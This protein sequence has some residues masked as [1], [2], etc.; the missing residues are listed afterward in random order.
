[1]VHKN[2]ISDM[3]GLFQVLWGMLPPNDHC[4]PMFVPGRL[5]PIVPFSLFRPHVA[6]AGAAWRCRFHAS[7]SSENCARAS[8]TSFKSWRRWVEAAWNGSNLLAS[9]MRSGKPSCCS[10]VSR[11][12]RVCS[13]MEVF[14]FAWQVAFRRSKFLHSYLG[15]CWE[16]YS[17]WNGSYLEHCSHSTCSS[18]ITFLDALLVWR[19]ILHLCAYVEVSGYVF[20]SDL[21]AISH[22]RSLQEDLARLEFASKRHLLATCPLA[23]SWALV[24]HGFRFWPEHL[25]AVADLN[26]SGVPPSPTRGKLNH[27]PLKKW[28]VWSRPFHNTWVPLLYWLCFTLCIGLAESCLPLCCGV[29]SILDRAEEVARREGQGTKRC[30][31]GSFACRRS[32]SLQTKG[33]ISSLATTTAPFVAAIYETFIEART[34]PID[35]AFDQIRWNPS[36]SYFFYRCAVCQQFGECWCYSIIK[37]W[38]VQ[39]VSTSSPRILS[40]RLRNWRGRRRLRSWP[41]RG[42]SDRATLW[43]FTADCL[44]LKGCSS[45]Q[46]ST[47]RTWSD[48][49]LFLRLPQ[50]SRLPSWCTLARRWLEF[51]HV[52]KKQTV[53]FH[54][55]PCK[56][57]DLYV[58]LIRGWILCEPISSAWF[59]AQIQ[60]IPGKMVTHNW[61]NLFRDLMA[62]VIADAFGRT[63]LWNPLN[64]LLDSCAAI[65]KAWRFWQKP[66]RFIN[67]F[68]TPIGFVPSPSISMQASVEQ[69]RTETSIRSPRS[70]IQL[71]GGLEHFCHIL[72]I[73]IPNWLI[74]FREVQTTNQPVCVCVCKTPFFSTK[75]LHWMNRVRASSV[76]WTNSTWWRCW[77]RK[78]QNLQ[79]FL[80]WMP[81]E[82][83]PTCLVCCWVGWSASFGNGSETF[84]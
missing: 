60:V 49:K 83:L 52:Q 29:I 62:T 31:H 36:P 12:L 45:T 2:S 78:V 71:A 3:F 68:R 73:I 17:S 15:P 24:L 22:P 43:T 72:G 18:C 38:V 13:W 7:G 48:S 10:H 57:T 34:V 66:S 79:K 61:S 56:H 55:R 5:S 16:Q 70:H 28:H 35:S 25:H 51:K 11:H 14:G 6:S 21:L 84:S 74:F 4:W 69:T 58:E 39:I 53:C 40:I 1:M 41:D 44:T 64:L 75:T 33:F 30:C 19:I 76:K 9:E 65:K 32:T 26:W 63:H 77:P 20:R 82:P 42:M 80:Q 47:P 46:Q 50:A 27:G 37:S 54:S 23:W 8:I 59:W 67:V 81:T